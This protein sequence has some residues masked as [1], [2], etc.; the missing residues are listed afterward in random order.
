MSV[1]KKK[2][3]T[4][5]EKIE[6]MET[7]LDLDSFITGDKNS[8]EQI[9]SYFKTNNPAYRRVHNKEGFMHFHVSKTGTFSEDDAYYQPNVVSRFIKPGAR[10]LELGY[11]QGANILYLAGKHP[12]AEFYGLDLSDPLELKKP[13]K[14]LKLLQQDY[15]DMS[16]FEDHSFDVVF[17]IETI[18]YCSD[19]NPVFREVHRVLKPGGVFIIIDY[20]L[21]A[22]FE[23]FSP[24]EQKAITLISKGGAAALIESVAEWKDLAVANGF[25]VETLTDLSKEV[26]PDLKRLERSA[27]THVMDHPMR[28]RIIFNTLPKQFVSNIILGYLG[29][30]SDVE[31]I[32]TYKEW[33]LRNH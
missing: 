21:P 29:Y 18:V 15:S 19:K 2:R 27:A 10:V 24:V 5:R 17:G 20:A 22:K 28:A 4:V 8:T 33:I 32:I 30:G 14:N 9:R 23:T 11:G 13:V 12:E 31:G 1:A 3:D 26:L 16:N 6:Y 7:F 25:A